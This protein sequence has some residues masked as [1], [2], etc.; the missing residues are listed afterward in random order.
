MFPE[1][2]K[3]ATSINAV[4]KFTKNKANGRKIVEEPNPAVV[5]IISAMK[6]KTKNN[7]STII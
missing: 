1:M 2:W 5:P 7:N 4:L 3:K 6:A